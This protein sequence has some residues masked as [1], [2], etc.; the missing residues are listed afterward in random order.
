MKISISE[1]N[2][3]QLLVYIPK[4]LNVFDTKTHIG[5]KYFNNSE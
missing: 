5:Q 4:S 2:K 3:T 1:S